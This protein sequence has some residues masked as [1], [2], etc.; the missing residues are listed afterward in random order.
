MND[1]IERLKGARARYASAPS[2]DRELPKK[3]TYC[4]ITSFWTIN[5]PSYKSNLAYHTFADAMYNGKGEWSII[6]FNATHST[7]EVLA[8]Y[9]R[10]IANQKEINDR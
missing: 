6:E 2:H 4:P 5:G 10:A 7:E 9:D 3:E 1:I 8:I